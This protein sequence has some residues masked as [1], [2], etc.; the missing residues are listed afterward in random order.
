MNEKEYLLSKLPPLKNYH[1]TIVKDQDTHDI[2]NELLNSHEIFKS[3][4]DKI[5]NEFFSPDN[6]R[7]LQSLFAFC[8]KYIPYKIESDEIQSSRSPAAILLNPGDCKHYAS[9]IGGVLDS[10][11]RKGNNINWYYRFANY[12]PFSH[13]V[14][15]VFVMAKIKGK[16]IWIDPVLSYFDSREKIPY[17]YIDKK[18]KSTKMLQRISG[19]GAMSPQLQSAIMLLNDYGIIDIK[20]RQI[21]DRLYHDTLNHLKGADKINLRNAYFLFLQSG[22]NKISGLWD[23]ISDLGKTIFA[24]DADADKA[25]AQFYEQQLQYQQQLELQKQKSSITQYLPYIAIGGIA[26]FFILKKK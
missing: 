12:N 2:I 3:D 9:F 16:E 13:D 1:K 14:G 10:L 23:F 21:N 22:T 25:R 19:I 18:I 11:N 6:E 26:L 7:I 5:S 20:R 8:K 24:P 15:H 4:Y 17:F